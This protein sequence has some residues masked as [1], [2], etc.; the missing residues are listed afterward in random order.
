MYVR[1]CVCVCVCMYVCMCVYM[2]VYICVCVYMY[3]LCVCECMFVCTYMYGV[4]ECM[5]TVQSKS[6]RNKAIKTK[7]RRRVFFLFIYSK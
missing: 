1:T 5:Y 4:Y 7:K 6:S 2:Y 3:V